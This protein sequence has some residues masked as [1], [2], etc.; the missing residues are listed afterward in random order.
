M[1]KLNLYLIILIM[2]LVTLSSVTALAAMDGTAS[3]DAQE[4]YAS[5]K[6]DLQAVTYNDFYNNKVG[7]DN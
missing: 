5:V 3:G 6:S 1:K 2:L 7:N 4:L